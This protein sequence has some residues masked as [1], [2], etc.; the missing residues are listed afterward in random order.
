MTC[1]IWKAGSDAVSYDV[2]GRLMVIIY[3][4]VFQILLLG[5][6]V[7]RWWFMVYLNACSGILACC[8]LFVLI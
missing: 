3:M 7:V 1:R 5:I 2:F 8:E 4:A 6:F